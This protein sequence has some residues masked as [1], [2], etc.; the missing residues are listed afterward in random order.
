[1]SDGTI[2]KEQFDVAFAEIKAPK[3]DS[4]TRLHIQD[5]WALTSLAKDTIDLLPAGYQLTVYELRFQAGL[6]MW[7]EIGTGYLPRVKN[8]THCLIRCM[9]LLKPSG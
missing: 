5:K 3:D 2:L 8:D 6:Y 9:E 4:S 7:T 1:M